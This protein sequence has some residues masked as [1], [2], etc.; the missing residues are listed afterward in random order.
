MHLGI[1]SA[2]VMVLNLPFGYWRAHARR[3]SV[4]WF[5]A[6]HVPVLLAVSLRV[7]GGL[8]WHLVTF[9]VL[10]GAYCLGQFLGG[11]I[12]GQ[13]KKRV[14]RP[15]TAC[16]VCDLWRKLYQDGTRTL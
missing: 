16:L 7:L 5:L 10:V 2:T 6:V 15:L 12:H 13:W 4:Q 8:G 3:F 11:T 14:G 9:P 1:V